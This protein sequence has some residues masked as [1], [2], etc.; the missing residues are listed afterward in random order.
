MINKGL[1]YAVGAYIIWGVLPIYWKA[2]HMVPAAEIVSHR[3]VWSLVFTVGLLAINRHWAWIIALRKQPKTLVIVFAAGAI[4]ALNWLTYVWAVNAGYVVETSLGYFINPL[5]S[6]L[7]GVVFLHEQL[8]GW[9]WVALTVALAGVLYLTA[10]HGSVPWIALFLAFSFG[11]YGLLKKFTALTALEG[12]SLETALLFPPAF[13]YLAFLEWQ[14]AGSLGHVDFT[15]T[16]LL[17][18]TGVAT[19]FPLLLFAAA[20]RQI[21]LSMLGFLQYMAPT[22]QFLLGVF[23]YHEPFNQIQ[24]IGFGLIW[25]ALVIYSVEGFFIRRNR[26][27]AHS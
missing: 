8:R 25:V 24:L 17:I 23:V 22:L 16:L 11:L 10:I 20:V 4:L 1:L 18:F 19:G 3:M 6:V 2:L 27:Y 13:G 21:P 5:V 9:Q 12:L 15:T 7:L 14:G 26:I